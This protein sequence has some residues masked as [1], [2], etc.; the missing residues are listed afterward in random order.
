MKEKQ[1][2]TSVWVNVKDYNYL[3]VNQVKLA[4]FVR[5]CLRLYRNDNLFKCLVH[6]CTIDAKR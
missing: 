2:C 3:K 1:Q 5:Q 6:G 4:T